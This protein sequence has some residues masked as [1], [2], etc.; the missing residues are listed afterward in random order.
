MCVILRAN[1]PLYNHKILFKYSMHVD[2]QNR[3]VEKNNFSFFIY[4][5]SV[6]CKNKFKI[7]VQIP[8]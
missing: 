4:L 3:V 7:L 1:M 2:G 5:L 8:K 6:I